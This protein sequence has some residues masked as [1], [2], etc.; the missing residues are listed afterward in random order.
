[1]QDLNIAEDLAQEI[2]ENNEY[3]KDD[4]GNFISRQQAVDREYISE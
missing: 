1:M 3:F 4:D 2:V